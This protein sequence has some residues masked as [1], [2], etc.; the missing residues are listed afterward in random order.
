[1]P[2]AK[3]TPAPFT[4]PTLKLKGAHKI[5][6]VQSTNAKPFSSMDPGATCRDRQGR[7]YHVNVDAS[8]V[9]FNQPGVYTVAYACIDGAGE[10]IATSS[11]S[12]F[13]ATKRQQVDDDG[14]G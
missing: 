12:V 1:M 10:V 8:A 5:Y 13:V 4:V 7:S 6:T 2:S 14:W 9:K 3:P 11:R